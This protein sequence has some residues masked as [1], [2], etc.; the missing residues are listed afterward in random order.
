[1]DVCMHVRMCG[2]I[3]VCMMGGCIYSSPLLCLPYSAS[4]TLPPPYHVIYHLP[5]KDNNTPTHH[6]LATSS[7]HSLPTYLLTSLHSIPFISL[8]SRRHVTSHL[9]TSH[10]ITSSNRQHAKRGCGVHASHDWL[11]E[12]RGKGYLPGWTYLNRRI[13]HVYVVYACTFFCLHHCGSFRSDA[14]VQSIIP[15]PMIC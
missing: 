13:V 10:H 2:C 1:M 6:H 15:P 9:I 11:R 14:E 8:T 4:L 3:Y 12:M 7:P 5:T